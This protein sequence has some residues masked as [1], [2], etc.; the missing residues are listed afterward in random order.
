MLTARNLY[1]APF[2]FRPSFKMMINTNSLPTV[3]D[4]TLFTSNRV[5]IITFDRHFTPE[6]Q[7]PNLK[8]ELI[9][10]ENMSAIL[11]WAL[12]GL[13]LFRFTGERPPA[14]VLTATEK[15]HTSS[16][17]I[18]R[19][20]AECMEKSDANTS[21][22]DTYDC[23]SD[24]CTCTGYAVDSKGSFFTALRERGLM[25]QT[26]TVNGKTERNVICGYSIISAS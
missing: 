5:R 10:E 26:G 17:K 15:F 19:F 1:Q 20:F 14:S 6:E 12:E 23:Y 18:V 13:K 9:Q 3:T 7:N 11:N 25:K 21:G 16:D 22:S 24:W 2:E 8:K 4:S